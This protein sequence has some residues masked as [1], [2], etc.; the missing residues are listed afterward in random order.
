MGTTRSSSIAP[1]LFITRH[2]QGRNLF[3]RVRNGEALSISHAHNN[4]CTLITFLWLYHGFVSHA[5]G[6]G[7]MGGNLSSSFHGTRDGT[8]IWDTL[9]NGTAGVSQRREEDSPCRVLMVFCFCARKGGENRH[10]HHQCLPFLVVEM[11]GLHRYEISI[12][13]YL[14]LIPS[15]LA[16]LHHSTRCI[17]AFHLAGLIPIHPRVPPSSHHPSNGSCSYPCSVLHPFTTYPLLPPFS[18]LDLSSQHQ[19]HAM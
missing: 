4:I 12:V 6:S 5:Y 2:L 13:L 11:A 10:H 19:L 16:I 18:P 7:W 14:Y 9:N 3:H 15:L 1:T 8:H 17:P